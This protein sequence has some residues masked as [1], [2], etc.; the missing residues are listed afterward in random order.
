MSIGTCPLHILHTSFRKGMTSTEWTIDESIND[1]WFWFS[2]SAAR[3]EDFVKV[4]NSI[5][6]GYA[7]FLH[8]FV[9]TRWIEIGIVLERIIEQWN[10]IN[11]YF[12]IFL[13][14]SDKILDR[15]DRFQR[16]KTMLENK[17]TTARFH[18][19]LYLYRNIFKKALVW[20]Q[21]EQPLVHVLYN[22]CCNVLRSVL[23]C[24]V[25][26]EVIAFKQGTQLL[27]ISYELQNNQRIDSK[28]EIGESTRNCLNHLSSN[29]K[30]A[31]YKDI[32]EIYCTITVSN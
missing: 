13:P 25:N 9:C 31:F 2:R 1:M 14:K 17:L 27:S 19:I 4:A 10:I 20:F 26:D 30:T 21:Q 18:F 12:L 32:R 29:E 24:F 5:V 23:L 16:I 28:I 7:H 8:R 15:N 22:E 3:R 11:E 6:E